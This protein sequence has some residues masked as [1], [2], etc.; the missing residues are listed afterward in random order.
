MKLISREKSSQSVRGSQSIKAEHSGRYFSSDV[1]PMENIP[2][3]AY[4]HS[5]TREHITYPLLSPKDS[6]SEPK[7]WTQKDKI[8]EENTNRTISSCDRKVFNIKER[9]S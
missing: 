6:S 5:S 2:S 7:N 8:S 1:M 4:A 3:R 9:R